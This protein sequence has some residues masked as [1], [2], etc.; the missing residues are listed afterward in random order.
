MLNSQEIIKLQ[1]L[2]L[3]SYLSEDVTSYIYLKM[4]MKLFKE[5][6]KQTSVL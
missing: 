5:L 6:S 1:N 4:T 3:D 2:I